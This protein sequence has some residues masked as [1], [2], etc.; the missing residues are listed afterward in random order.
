MTASAQSL[1][2][3]GWGAACSNSAARRATT[4]STGTTSNAS[5]K[6]DVLCVSEGLAPDQISRILRA[7]QASGSPPSAAK[8]DTTS[9]VSQRPRNTQMRT[10]ESTKY[11]A[12]PAQAGAEASKIAVDGRLGG[13]FRVGLVAPTSPRPA[14]RVLE[15]QHLKPGLHGFSNEPASLANRDHSLELDEDGIREHDLGFHGY[16]P[17]NTSICRRSRRVKG[18]P[19]TT[20]R[21]GWWTSRSIP[22][23]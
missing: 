16:P 4:R 15:T 19:P 2:K 11:L 20:G 17:I 6:T 5:S 22:S 1:G 7:E 9:T 12:M 14:Q 13:Q 3:D 23:R 10:S 8:R 18:P 21:T